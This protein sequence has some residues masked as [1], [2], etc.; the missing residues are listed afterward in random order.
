M[1]YAKVPNNE[2]IE[3]SIVALKNHGI[4]SI[5]VEN[6]ERALKEIL[7]NILDGSKVMNGSST[8]LIQIGFSDLLKSGNHKWKNLHK[9]ILKEADYGKQSDLR[10]KAIT[11][12]ERAMK[13]SME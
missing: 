8:T 5:L 7:K 3:K 1:D 12:T 6:K 9:D 13:K 2:I 10:K 4:D 11:E